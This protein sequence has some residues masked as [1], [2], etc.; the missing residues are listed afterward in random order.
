MESKTVRQLQDYCRENNI[1]GYSK[2]KKSELIELIQRHIVFQ[3]DYDLFSKPKKE[4][5]LKVKCS[6]QYY[7]K[8]Y[9]K[10]HLQSKNHQEY[11]NFFSFD[12]KKASKPAPPTSD[13][14]D[15]VDEMTRVE[16]SFLSRLQTWVIRNARNFK[17]PTAFLENCRTMVIKKL[18]QRVGVKANFQLYCDYQREQETQEFS[19]KTMNQIIL[20]STDLNEFYSEVVDKLKREMGEFEARGSG[21]RLIEIKYLELRI[22]KYNPLRVSPYIDL[23]KTIKAKKAVIN[24]NRVDDNKCFMCAILCALHPADDHVDRISK[25][26]PYENDLNF[27]GI[28]FPIKMEDRVFKRC[29]VFFHSEKDLQAHEMDC[30][31]N[32]A[33]KI[34]MPQQNS[35]IKFKNYHKSF[36]TPF[37]M[38]ADFE[39]LTTKIDICQPDDNSP[40]M[41][42]YQ[43][44]EPMSSS[45]HIKSKYGDYKPPITYR[46]P[47]AT[48]VFYDSEI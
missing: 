8:S 16:M 23:P 18:S 21:W 43:R 35:C 7:K 38:H 15:Y 47:N 30:K 48:K 10:Q 34:V 22:N 44:H 9:M 5:E 19:F 42:K 37:V 2:L 11:E 32:Q 41:Q 17:G 12:K 36:R 29:L 45:L 26:K 40:Y 33:V 24:V 39:C 46:G 28:E 27:E 13:T 31:K 3:F 14:F 25:N 1:R 6:D 20:E 4:R